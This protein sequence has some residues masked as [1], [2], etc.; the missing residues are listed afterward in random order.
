MPRIILSS[1]F[2]RFRV[3]L[4]LNI[5]Q[6]MWTK[7]NVASDYLYEIEYT[8]PDEQCSYFRF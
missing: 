3:S 4:Y 7:S 2:S 5:N 6:R 8:E 1:L